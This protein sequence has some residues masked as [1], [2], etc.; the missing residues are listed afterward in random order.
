MVKRKLTE[1]S[2]QVLMFLCVILLLFQMFW[3]AAILYILWY[4]LYGFV[5][6]SFFFYRKKACFIRFAF[7]GYFL[8]Y[9]ATI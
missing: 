2:G 7:K 1:Y 4:A 5:G 3:G 6:L 9:I 8:P